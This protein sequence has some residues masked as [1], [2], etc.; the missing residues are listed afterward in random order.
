MFRYSSWLPNMNCVRN[1][2]NESKY[3]SKCSVLDPNSYSNILILQQ[4]SLNYFLNAFNFKVYLNR[5]KVQYTFSESYYWLQSIS[6]FCYVYFLLINIQCVEDGCRY[7]SWLFYYS[8]LTVSV[9]WDMLARLHVR[10]I[11]LTSRTFSL[12]T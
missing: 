7:I 6:A 3:L 11:S 8:S 2:D 5:N 12:S 1:Q 9:T 10:S 4:P